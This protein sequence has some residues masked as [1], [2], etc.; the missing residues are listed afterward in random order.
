MSSGAWMMVLAGVIMFGTL[1]WLV[2]GMA[3]TIRNE[4]N[5]RR[6]IWREFG[7]GLILMLLFFAAWFAQ[8]ITQ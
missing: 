1:G 5:P 6:S 7:L 2:V 3:R 4:Q 8:G